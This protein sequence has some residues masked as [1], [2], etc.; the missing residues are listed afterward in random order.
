METQVL[1]RRTAD[2]DADQSPAVMMDRDL[3]GL[4]L[5]PKDKV[6]TQAE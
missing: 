2:F 1:E 3:R 5:H 6:T 4:L